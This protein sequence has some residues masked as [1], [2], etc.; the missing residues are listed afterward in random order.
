M[1]ITGLLALIMVV[2]VAA[3]AGPAKVGKPV[4]T[5]ALSV[6]TNGFEPAKVKVKAG[7]RVRLVVTRRTDRTCATELVMKAMK[8]HKAL[9]LNQAVE[10]FFTPKKAGTLRYACGMDMIAGEV[11]VE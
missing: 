6:T 5:I 4:Q 1:R 7:V 9:P 11:I 3:V 8:I 10:I 2:A